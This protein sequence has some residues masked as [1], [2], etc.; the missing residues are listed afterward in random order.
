MTGTV[1]VVLDLDHSLI[2]PYDVD[3]SQVPWIGGEQGIAYVK[4]RLSEIQEANKQQG[5]K[6]L[7]AIVTARTW[8]TAD[9]YFIMESLL[10]FLDNDITFS[11]RDG[12]HFFIGA[13]NVDGYP[14]DFLYH[15]SSGK[16]ALPSGD[17]QSFLHAGR[18]PQ[19]LFWPGQKSEAI[20]RIANASEVP[21][22]QIF[23]VDDAH[24]VH[25][26]VRRFGMN[27]ASTAAFLP[28]G[29][30]VDDLG[31]F[32]KVL[33]R[34]TS[35]Y[36]SLEKQITT[37][38]QY[39]TDKEAKRF[40]ILFDEKPVTTKIVTGFF[41]QL[42]RSGVL[43]ASNISTNGMLN[44][45][46]TTLESDGISALL[47]Q[48]EPGIFFDEATYLIS[49]TGTQYVVFKEPNME[50]A[51]SQFVYRD[52]IAT[53]CK[54]YLVQ[55]VTD[56]SDWK[57]IRVSMGHDKNQ[58]C[59][60]EEALLD[61]MDNAECFKEGE[62]EYRLMPLPTL[63]FNQYHTLTLP[64][65]AQNPLT[66]F[67]FI[68]KT[69]EA[70][71][72]FG[73]S[74]DIPALEW[75][76]KGLSQTAL[77]KETPAAASSAEKACTRE[78]RQEKLYRL[79]NDIVYI[80]TGSPIERLDNTLLLNNRMA[81]GTAIASKE[82]WGKISTIPLCPFYQQV[83]FV[84]FVLELEKIAHHEKLGDDA[85]NPFD[86]MRKIIIAHEDAA[87]A[88]YNAIN[89]SSDSEL[90]GH[91]NV[92]EATFLKELRRFHKLCTENFLNPTPEDFDQTFMRTRILCRC[93]TE[94]SFLSDQ[95]LDTLLLPFAL[96]DHQLALIKR[97][98]TAWR[99]LDTKLD[100][101]DLWQEALYSA[102]T[103]KEAEF[104]RTLVSWRV[105]GLATARVLDSGPI[106]NASIL[107]AFINKQ[108]RDGAYQP[109][110]WAVAMVC[111]LLLAGADPYMPKDDGWTVLYDLVRYGQKVFDIT[112]AV[113]D[114]GV[115][116]FFYQTTREME[117]RPFDCLGRLT[118][119]YLT[120]IA[121][122]MGIAPEAPEEQEK[123]SRLLDESRQLRLYATLQHNLTVHAENNLSSKDV[124]LMEEAKP[125]V[126]YR[127]NQ[128]MHDFL[129]ALQQTLAHPK[130]LIEKPIFPGY[131]ILTRASEQ[132]GWSC[133]DIAVGVSREEIVD[134]AL[135]NMRHKDLRAL[136]A[137]E[138][139]SAILL[140]YAYLQEGSNPVT[141]Q[142]QTLPLSMRTEEM[143]RMAQACLDIETA[144]KPRLQEC[145]ALL[146]RVE[147]S[148]L[149]WFELS[150]FF[151]QVVD[152][153]PNAERF[154]PAY[155]VYLSSIRE[156]EAPK[157]RL[158]QYAS[159]ADIYEQYITD[160]YG[161]KQ[162]FS[163][164]GVD[165][166]TSMIDLVARMKKA[167]IVIHLSDERLY[168]TEAYGDT[169]IHVGYCNGNHFV[170]LEAVDALV[171]ELPTP[172]TVTSS[173]LSSEVGFFAQRLV[174][175]P[176]VVDVATQ[177]T[178]P[179]FI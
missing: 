7:F 177:T 122:L 97:R 61:G 65:D 93:L 127:P 48:L 80:A 120:K 49:A 146:G 101:S 129:A 39:L 35:V 157:E 14:E 119:D 133:F 63:P 75:T 24:A 34:L 59:L 106:P 91:V 162:W 70:Y 153:I 148:I 92:W 145:N 29:R 112:H 158:Y 26:D 69:L 85:F 81:K 3:A 78:Q 66:K 168:K 51:E 138:I 147:G 50:L 108:I 28:V 67:A 136:V 32:Q 38:R 90:F 109:N 25:R 130:E 57:M 176:N 164:A 17:S 118:G 144:L 140:T 21:F 18:T 124:F 4:Q 128:M 169:T 174:T 172:T 98:I 173:L 44:A 170:R 47:T 74:T 9:T 86:E 33:P 103:E 71:E 125:R 116:P 56:A 30:S 113:M 178:E 154:L 135:D 76:D 96:H 62:L 88:Q 31:S 83:D 141:Q 84:N 89:H 10:P 115:S 160:Y 8:P 105:P 19:I 175:A 53:G 102:N 123:T 58:L 82:R 73:D 143:Q 150:S 77:K 163:F 100:V 72:S 11:H 1:L 114:A 64:G 68:Q 37:L 54:Y 159:R 166:Q 16:K 23:V 42:M 55:N 132:D 5:I 165:S 171:T 149:N 167:Q 40:N 126:V 117:E 137:P 142:Q 104:L 139:M 79:I 52:D 15:F 111:E 45:T 134:Y 41:Q 155:D 27:V 179:D 152:G 20:I 6:T 99:R 60:N 121:F 22:N 161:N 13:K 46:K 43:Q 110:N 2:A 94:D 156:L 87:A 131:E 151:E 36:D 95:R 107:H 12:A